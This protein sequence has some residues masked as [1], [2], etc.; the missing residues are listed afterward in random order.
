M[1]FTNTTRLQDLAAA[2]LWCKGESQKEIAAKLGL[3]VR[4]VQLAL[5]RAKADHWYS[6]KPLFRPDK[7]AAAEL[8]DLETCYDQRPG[9]IDGLLR[10]PLKEIRVIMG[11]TQK[12]FG[13]HAAPHV[14]G[15]FRLA[16]SIGV[17]W[18]TDL[19]AVVSGIEE[20]SEPLES[21]ELCFFPVRG[22]PLRGGDPERGPSRLVRRLH[23]Y[24]NRTGKAHSLT[25]FPATIP[26]RA[27]TPALCQAIEAIYGD[28]EDYQRIIAGPE[29]LLGRTDGIL[30]SVGAATVSSAWTAASLFTGYRRKF[31]PED[32]LAG[33]MAGVALPCRAEE[34][35][36]ESD[37]AI[38]GQVRSCFLGLKYD[39]LVRAA[40]K[41]P[42]VILCAWSEQKA[43][44][45]RRACQ[46]GLVT[47]LLISGELA[48]ALAA[49]SVENTRR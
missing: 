25:G 35:L 21:K 30:T 7:F 10:P 11:R 37:R 8:A 3:N 44:A 43:K 38:L 31:W 9:T 15:Y 49:A 40:G 45:V 2:Y 1:A 22:E 20:L 29:A 19:A 16:T 26:L 36:S 28:S 33:D 23:D 46:L 34:D 4:K 5:D 14:I 32:L 48:V 17:A 47:R 27:D 41:D 39:H 18:G 12:E 6:D 13:R 24:W 42:G